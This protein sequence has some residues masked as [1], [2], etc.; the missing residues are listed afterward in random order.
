MERGEAITKGGISSSAKLELIRPPWS[1]LRH[2]GS[3]LVGLSSN[4]P[5]WVFVTVRWIAL[6]RSIL[7]TKCVDT[8]PPL[9]LSYRMAGN[10]IPI[11]PCPKCG[12]KLILVVTPGSYQSRTFE[13]FNCNRPLSLRRDKAPDS[14]Q[15]S[16]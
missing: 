1:K 6:E 5:R 16:K 4:Q 15:P 11:A 3:A 10:L 7:L 13:C 8:L 9:S 12:N 14:P 2:A